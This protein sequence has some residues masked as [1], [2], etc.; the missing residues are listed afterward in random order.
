MLFTDGPTRGRV[1]RSAEGEDTFVTVLA[2]FRRGLRP[3]WADAAHRRGGQLRF[4]G[5]LSLRF[6]DAVWRGSVLA[7][8]GEVLEAGAGPPRP[9]P[10]G[11]V[12]LVA[13]VRVV[14]RCSKG[15]R[16]FAVEL[17]LTRGPTG[18]QVLQKDMEAA[19]AAVDAGGA[20]DE[21]ARLMAE[22]AAVGER[23]R[24][25][26]AEAVEAAGVTTR[27]GKPA[28]V[29]ALLYR[30]HAAS[31]AREAVLGGRGASLEASRAEAGKAVA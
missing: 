27:A 22:V 15:V 3:D 30:P 14:D 1:S 18:D 9:T 10:G 4:R 2:A 24:A 11:S 8:A 25:G 17:W 29:P 6:V 16:R 13:G 12:P 20:A 5:K 26:M 31:L 21:Q 23:W 7:A 28:F 19:R